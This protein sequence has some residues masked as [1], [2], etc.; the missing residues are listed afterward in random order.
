MNVPCTPHNNQKT[1][2]TSWDG[3]KKRSVVK[4]LFYL[5]Q[6]LRVQAVDYS[7]ESVVPRSDMRSSTVAPELFT[8]QTQ[9]TVS[10]QTVK[11]GSPHSPYASC[12]SWQCAVCAQSP[13]VG[14]A[15]SGAPASCSSA[16][17]FG[18]RSTSLWMRNQNDVHTYRLRLLLCLRNCTFYFSPLIIFIV[19]LYKFGWYNIFISSIKCL[20]SL[21]KYIFFTKR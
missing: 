17:S 13:W 5:R 14:R 6:T 12:Q 15:W 20:L 1:K 11:D 9:H 19:L 4:T 3:Q 8:K 16:P 10:W 18:F 2:L 21:R 7:E